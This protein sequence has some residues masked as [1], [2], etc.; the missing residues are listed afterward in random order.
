MRLAGLELP[1]P[2]CRKGPWFIASWRGFLRVAQKKNVC[3]CRSVLS[4]FQ[5]KASKV[6]ASGMS[7]VSSSSHG[8]SVI[9]TKPTSP[10]PQLSHWTVFTLHFTSLLELAAPSRPRTPCVLL[11]SLD[12]SRPE[13]SW[14]LPSPSLPAACSL[15]LWAR[16]HLPSREH[17]QWVGAE[18]RAEVSLA[19]QSGGWLRINTMWLTQ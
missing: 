9:S 11:G 14:L 4:L 3:F 5:I 17:G 16:E 15:F 7:P 6:Q 1:L 2:F 8:F 19:G 13:G 12:L 18:R 10:S